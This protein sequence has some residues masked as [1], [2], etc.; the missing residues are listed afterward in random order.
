SAVLYKHVHKLVAHSGVRLLTRTTR[1]LGLTEAGE[2][3]Y[4]EASQLLQQLDDLDAT[5]SDPPAER[6]GLIRFSAPRTLGETTL[7]PAIFAFMAQNP[8]V[9][10]DLRLED[11]YVD[12]V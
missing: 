7:S 10:V 12:L 5:I 3:Y 9:A 2:A 6:R 11:R 4:R 1:K 8:L